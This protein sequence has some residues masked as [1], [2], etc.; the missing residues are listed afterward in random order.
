MMTETGGTM[1]CSLKGKNGEVGC[2]QWMPGNWP[3]VSKRYLGYV[4][5]MTKVNELYVLTLLTESQLAA[6]HSEGAIAR[7]HNQGN[8]GACVKGVNAQGVKYDSCAYQARVISY[9]NN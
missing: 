4:A 6:G 7:L 9:L 3:K 5:P 1:N 2:G 8:T